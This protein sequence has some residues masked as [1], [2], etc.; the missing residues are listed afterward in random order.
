MIL[1]SSMNVMCA[2][3]IKKMLNNIENL[4][5]LQQ[6]QTLLYCRLPI[7]SISGSHCI[8]LDILFL[9]IFNRNVSCL[10]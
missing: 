3:I 6:H 10:K 5:A 4:F 8:N 1:N 2:Q 7:P 9:L